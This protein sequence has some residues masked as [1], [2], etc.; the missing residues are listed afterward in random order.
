[1]DITDAERF[2]VVSEDRQKRVQVLHIANLIY[3]K[4][5]GLGIL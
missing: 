2:T 1:M 3:N 5:N 4:N